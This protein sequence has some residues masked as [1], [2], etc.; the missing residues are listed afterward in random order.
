MIT[1]HAVSLIV[2]IEQR[3]KLELVIKISR[4]KCTGLVLLKCT[5][6]GL[7]PMRQPLID[8]FFDSVVTIEVRRARKAIKSW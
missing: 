1:C 4:F 6:S 3:L 2:D 5:S 7:Y 8:F